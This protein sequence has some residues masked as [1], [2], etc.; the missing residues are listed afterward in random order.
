MSLADQRVRRA[1]TPVLKEL[2][3][4]I[5]TLY[6]SGRTHLA[7]TLIDHLARVRERACEAGAPTV[8]QFGGVDLVANGWGRQRYRYCLDHP[9]GWIGLS[10]GGYLPA[11]RIEPNSECLHGLGVQKTV[12]WF[13]GVVEAECGPVEWTVNRLDVYADWQGWSLSGNDRE[14]FVCRARACKIEEDNGQFESLQFGRRKTNTFSSRFYDKTAELRQKGNDWW[15]DVW[16]DRYD[17]ERPVLRV[18]IE[19][20]RTGLR[21]LGIRTPEQAIDLAGSVWKYGTEEFVSFR[22]AGFDSNKSRWLEAPEWTQI[23]QATLS[24]GALG[25]KRTNA[26]RLNGDWRKLAPFLN[27]TLT[28]F[29]AIIGASSIEETIAYLPRFVA[30]YEN[31]TAKSFADRVTLKR[32]R[33]AT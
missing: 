9:H 8:V 24:E 21:Q 2:S 1:A 17:P 12:D 15:F 3:S 25:M 4:G 32:R 29:A 23:R 22:T 26:G 28:S 18:E 14:R 16:G 13:R 11:I 5:D 20:G 19:C 10:P 30:W 33:L 6:L 31:Q 7:E 27:G